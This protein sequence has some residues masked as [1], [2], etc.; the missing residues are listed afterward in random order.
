M[1]LDVKKQYA[2]PL[3]DKENIYPIDDEHL[4]FTINDQ[5]LVFFNV[6]LR[7]QR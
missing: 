6:T 7:N 2:L 1:I 5:L 3:Y 4:V